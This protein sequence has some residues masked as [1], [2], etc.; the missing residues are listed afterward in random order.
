MILGSVVWK[1]DRSV[2][3]SSKR[4]VA[5]LCAAPF[6][7]AKTGVENISEILQIGVITPRCK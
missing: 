5:K 3:K 6:G 1:F 7:G 2:V 4:S